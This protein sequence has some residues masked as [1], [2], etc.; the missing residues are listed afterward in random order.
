MGTL[1]FP[2]EREPF[3]CVCWSLDQTFS[4]LQSSD[5]YPWSVNQILGSSSD[6]WKPSYHS[7]W[8]ASTTKIMLTTKP[9]TWLNCIKDIDFIRTKQRV[10]VMHSSTY[11]VPTFGRQKQEDLCEFEA[12]LVYLC[13]LQARYDFIMRS[14]FKT[15]QNTRNTF[16]ISYLLPFLSYGFF[17]LLFFWA[18]HSCVISP[19]LVHNYLFILLSY[20]WL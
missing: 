15:K 12:S 7:A 9:C 18:S 8:C 17:M 19:E 1:P 20:Q 4:N 16:V 10:L 2:E 13:E 3:L 5:L 6:P 14:C 11:L